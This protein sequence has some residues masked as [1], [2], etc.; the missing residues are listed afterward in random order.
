MKD[1]QLKLLSETPVSQAITRMGIPAIAS[2]LIMAI[3]NMVDTLFIGMLHDDH[4]LAAVAIAFP[5]MT[6]MTAVGQIFGAGAASTIGRSFGSQ[7]DDYASKTATTIIFTSI[8]AGILFMLLGISLIEPIFK[9]FGTTDSVMPKAIEY[10][11]WMYIGSLFSIPNQSFNNMARAEAKATLSMR[12][13]MLGAVSNIILDPIFM[14]DLGGFGFNMGIRGASMATTLAQIISFIFI[15]SH[16][17]GGKTRVQ[18]KRKNF[19]PSKELY[20]DVLRAGMPSGVTLMLSSLA[21]SVTNLTAVSVAPTVILA[22]NIQS[23]YG[24]VLKIT[25]M[26]Q[27]GLFGYFLGYQPIASYA[28][29]A[30]NKERFFASYHWTRKVMLCVSIPV[31]FI[32]EL[33]APSMI[34]AFTSNPEI[35]AIGAK[36][37][38]L[39]SMFFVFVGVTGL[40][41]ITFQSIGH[42]L[43]GSIIAIAR[44]GFLYIP[45]IITFGYVFGVDTIFYAQPLADIITLVISLVLYKSFLKQMDVYFST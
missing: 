17:F 8:G 9:L 19:S 4:A 1:K 5:I 43:K 20:G 33:F 31:T 2:T 34:S 6:L 11:T 3:Y 23:A 30:K 24:I 36:F 28:Y 42:G 13:L 39:N 32:I 18:V 15:S 27:Q 40:L 38:R 16:F 7:E 41:T 21:M 14:F 44:Q 26:V 35:I 37:L 12:S 25:S 10:G 22:E 45:L 29:G